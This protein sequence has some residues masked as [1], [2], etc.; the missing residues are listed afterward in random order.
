MI[1]KIESAGV[2]YRFSAERDG[3][4]VGHA[5]LHL[6]ENDLHH[7]PY[8]LLE[9]VWVDEDHRSHG[10]GAEMVAAVKE[11]AKLEHGCYKLIATSRD[12][13][14]RDWVHA[15]YLRLGFKDWGTEFRMDFPVR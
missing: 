4:E 9:D 11:C 8:G 1:R 2:R 10:V 3:R 14:T 15:W 6:I 7:R 13:G 5:W 12:D